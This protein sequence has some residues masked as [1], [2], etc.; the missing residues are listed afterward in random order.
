M[1][2]VSIGTATIQPL[3]GTPVSISNTEERFDS[4]RFPDEQS[5]FFKIQTETSSKLL[6]DSVL[7]DT[8][9][10]IIINQNIYWS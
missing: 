8:L 4:R 5:K 2:F 3:V 9:I 7:S 1:A 10:E 6:D